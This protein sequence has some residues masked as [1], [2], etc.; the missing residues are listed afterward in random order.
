M[1]NSFYSESELERIGF[2]SIGKNTL[3]SRFAR[4]YGVENMEIGN[5]V[6]I[7][8]F[9]IFS[10]NIIL[11]SHIH[12][13]AYNALYGSAGIEIQDFSGIS[14]RCTIFSASDDFSG[15]FLIGPMVDQKYT[16]VSKGL[17]SIEKYVQIGANSILMPKIRIEEGAAIAALSFINKDIKSWGIYGGIPVKFIKERTRKMIELSNKYENQKKGQL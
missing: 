6:R 8:D 5:N 7:D 3:I 1:D 10:G 15:D 16:N 13:S 12:I 14:P 11:G 4:F 17:V 9:C 2:K